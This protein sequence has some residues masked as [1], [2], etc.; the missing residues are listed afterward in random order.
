MRNN[1][2]YKPNLWRVS[3]RLLAMADRTGCDP[4]ALAQMVVTIA[5]PL[6]NAHAHAH[7]RGTLTFLNIKDRQDHADRRN[8]H[9]QQNRNPEYSGND[10]RYY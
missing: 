3:Q 7:A 5:T 2:T 1:P 9:E 4:D 10:K 6:L 8:I